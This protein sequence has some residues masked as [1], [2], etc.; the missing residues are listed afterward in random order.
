MA[1]RDCDFEASPPAFPPD[2]LPAFPFP[3]IAMCYEG[4]VCRVGGS[5]CERREWRVVVGEEGQVW[6]G[7]A[8]IV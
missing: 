6:S 4:V 8:R 3:D 1:E 5:G 2:D 7:G